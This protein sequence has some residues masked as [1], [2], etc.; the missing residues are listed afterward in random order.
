MDRN[1]QGFLKNQKKCKKAIFLGSGA[2]FPCLGILAQNHGFDHILTTNSSLRLI[3]GS[4]G[5]KSAGLSKK[6][7]SIFGHKIA[8]LFDI[9]VYSSFT[10][11]FQ[12]DSTSPYMVNHDQNN[13]N[14][15]KHFMILT[16]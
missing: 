13:Q 11:E 9:K 2:E 6:R 3:E 15:I 1:L 10:S 16:Q 14:R 7:V 12:D 8:H 5:S 4:F